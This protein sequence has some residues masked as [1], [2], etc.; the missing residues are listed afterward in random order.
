MTL[1]DSTRTTISP[2][3]TATLAASRARPHPASPAAERNEP[4]HALSWALALAALEEG[5]AADP[6][7]AR[8]SN[9]AE[10]ADDGEPHELT[11]VELLRRFAAGTL[12]PTALLSHL[13]PRW[14]DPGL[15]PEAV[16]RIIPGIDAAAAESDLRWAN[17]TARALEG[18]PFAVKDIIDVQG[19]VVTSGSAQTGDRVAPA[20]ATVVARLRLAGAIPVIMVATSEF[21][22]GDPRNGRYGAV[23]NPWNR[24]HWTGGSSTGSGAALAARLVPLALG[25][26]T[27]GS[28]RVPSTLCGVSGIKPSY[29]LVPRTG[30]ATLS[31]TLDHVGP[32]ARSAEDLAAVLPLI[33]GADG[34]D[35]TVPTHPIDLHTDVDRFAGTRIAA[36]RSW[37]TERTDDAVLARYRAALAVFEALGAEVVPLELDGIAEIHDESWVVFYSELASSQEANDD[38][39]DLFDAGTNARLDCGFIPSGVD[40]LRALRRRPMVQRAMVAAMADAGVDLLITPAVGAV[41][42]RLSDVT[43]SVNGQRFNHHDVIPRNTRVFDYTGMPALVVP[44]GAVDGLPTSIQIVA[45][46]WR[47]RVA[48][49]AGIAFQNATRHHLDAPEHS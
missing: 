26:D 19:A 46:P 49:S 13:R 36:P 24:E 23:R 48:L 10:D 31:W 39:R 32:M 20:D 43:M 25:T 33:A 45:A 47:D 16:L 21:A 1:A 9:P 29:G 35:P 3:L 7:A 42:P 4:Q 17:G 6:R 12:A 40:Y 27:G 41:A 34:D 11:V 15:A 30:V 8:T 14:T 38:R 44:M 28:I 18:I 5:P 22:C 2:Q 37:F